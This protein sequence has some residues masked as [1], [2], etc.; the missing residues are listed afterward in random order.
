VVFRIIGCY[1]RPGSLVFGYTLSSA[2]MVRS[3]LL[4][5]ALAGE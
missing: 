3:H 1:A 2:A 4:S 5:S